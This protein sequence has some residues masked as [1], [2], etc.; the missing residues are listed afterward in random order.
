MDTPRM[1]MSNRP[2]PRNRTRLS[3]KLAVIA[4]NSASS[5][6]RAEMKIELSR[7]RGKLPVLSTLK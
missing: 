1:V 4:R 6:V 3:A 5:T 2:R 7:F